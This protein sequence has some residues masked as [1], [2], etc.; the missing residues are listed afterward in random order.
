MLRLRSAETLLPQ[1]VRGLLTQGRRHVSAASF[2][3]WRVS[4][5][6]VT[7][8]KADPDGLPTGGGRRGQN[9]RQVPI[10]GQLSER[11]QY[12]KCDSTRLARLLCERFAWYLINASAFVKYYFAP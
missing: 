8:C 9:K 7:L 11:E 4:L 1:G 2:F 10:I 5:H 6:N 12:K 3:Y